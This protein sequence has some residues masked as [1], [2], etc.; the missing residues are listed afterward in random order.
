MSRLEVSHTRARFEAS[1]EVNGPEK[2][3]EKKACERKAQAWAEMG[4][5]IKEK[6]K[7]QT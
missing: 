2:E 4:R 7:K 3:E 1:A 5:G 6:K